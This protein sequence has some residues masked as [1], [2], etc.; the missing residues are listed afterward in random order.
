M[1]KIK[2]IELS[3]NRWREYRELRLEALQKDP[4]A[5]GQKYHKAVDFPDSYWTEHLE[6]TI[7]KDKLLVHF[8]ESNGKLIGMIEAFFHSN[9][10]TKDSAQIFS[11]YVTLAFRGRGIAKRLQAHLLLELGKTQGLKKVRVMVNKMQK[12][13]VNLYK[14]GNFKVISTQNKVLGDG[15]EY[16]I[17]TMEQ[18]LH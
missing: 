7:K 18:E 17:D 8:A 6:N 9:E 10:E 5:F 1:D 13:A 2:V 4:Q 15:K 3:P 16:E 11:V 12:S 14:D